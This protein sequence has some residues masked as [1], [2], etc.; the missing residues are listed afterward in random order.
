MVTARV[1]PINVDEVHIGQPVNVRFPSFASRTTPELFGQVTKIS[2]DAMVDDAT[3]AS[4]YRAEVVLD[5]NE[6]QKLGKLQ[7]L[8]GMPAEVYIR[9]GDRSPLAYLTKP[10][11][12]YFTRAF[13]EN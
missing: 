6:M 1:S 2:A 9:T 4:Y 3:H 10:F 12:D 11:T 5:Q 8:P 7:I 13:R